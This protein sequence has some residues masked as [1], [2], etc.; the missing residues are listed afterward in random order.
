MQGHAEGPEQLDPME[1]LFFSLNTSAA[2]L[3]GAVLGFERHYR[4]HPAGLRTNSL[5]SVGSA[6]FVAIS[7][8]FAHDPRVE[9]TRMASYVITGIGFLGGGVI[10]RE[11]VN[12]RGMNTAATLWC[13]AAIGTLCGLGFILEALLGAVFVLAI[14]VG[15]RPVSHWIDLNRKTASDVETSYRVRVECEEREQGVIRTIMLRHIN[16]L[17]KMT[18]QSIATQE[19]E[20]PG[21]VAVVAEVFSVERDDH[22]LD[23]MVARLTIEPGV[24][25]VKWEKR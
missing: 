2:L 10:M 19:C 1:Y 7:T 18:V 21:H 20:R 11:G 13:S 24:Q 8:L 4:G 25:S 15:L 6:L 5:V 22:A 16:A 14:N 9:P 23:E 17:A 12:V 3:M